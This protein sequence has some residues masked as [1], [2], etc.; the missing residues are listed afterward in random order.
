MNSF[1][2]DKKLE[3]GSFIAPNFSNLDE[4]YLQLLLLNWRIQI[5]R[6]NKNP[7]VF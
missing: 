5:I 6:P 1:M 2:Q 3:L 7:S 4:A